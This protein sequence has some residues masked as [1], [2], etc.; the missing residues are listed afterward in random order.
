MAL[1]TGNEA[2]VI[3]LADRRWRAVWVKAGLQSNITGLSLPSGETAREGEERR[4]ERDSPFPG[5]D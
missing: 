5:E 3:A 1:V 2:V 4:G